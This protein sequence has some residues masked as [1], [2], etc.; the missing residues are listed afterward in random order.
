M[1]NY[2]ELLAI[3]FTISFSSVFAQRVVNDHVGKYEKEGYHLVWSDEFD[4][5]GVPDTANWKFE[6]GFVRNKEK[7]WYQ[8]DNAWCDGG[9]LIIEARKEDKANPNYN[10]DSKQW[11][12]SR[13]KITHTSSSINTRGLHSWQ[14]GRFEMRGRIN[15]S[16]GLWP[17]F[18]TLGISK[19]WPSNGEIDIMEYYKGNIL[20]NIACGTDQPY[21]AKWYSKTKAVKELGG[22][23]WAS[24]FHVWRMDWDEEAIALYVDDILL[25]K[26]PLDE[27]VNRDGS[28]FNPF[29][30][31]H[32]I[33]LNLAMG[34]INGGDLGNT[35]FPNR[36]VVDYVRVYQKK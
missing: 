9:L 17:A 20:A 10:A 19:Q 7:Q 27:L 15:I 30:Q 8:K 6:E 32:Y 33:L 34:G 12:E 22:K 1:N 29:K 26:V 4:Q 3:I 24:E 18:W 14:Y 35:Q 21:Q 13:S 2:I 23:K 28:G 36:F 5:T 31:P 11:S 16:A 25:N